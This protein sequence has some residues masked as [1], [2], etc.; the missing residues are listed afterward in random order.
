MYYLISDLHAEFWFRNWHSRDYSRDAVNHISKWF[1]HTP[2]YIFVAG[3]IHPDPNIRE[4]F[5]NVVALAAR[6]HRDR[7][8]T[9]L[10]NH[11][12]YYRT[13]PYDDTGKV[14][15]I[16]GVK[17]LIGTMWTDQWNGDPIA[18]LNAA[19]HMTDGRVIAGWSPESMS[20]VFNRFVDMIKTEKPDA[21]MTHHAPFT[22][23]IH[24]KY[25]SYG[26]MNSLFCNDLSMPV[27]GLGEFLPKV[28]LHGHCHDPFDY[29]VEGSKRSCHVIAN[30]LGYPNELFKSA[31]IGEYRAK[32]FA[33]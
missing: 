4:E 19:K 9:V 22:K 29:M 31:H 11:D 2:S 16:D 7:V 14:I 18:T 1:E 32:S 17:W 10:G 13:F 12:W 8:I 3:D 26:S 24:R 27:Y 15:E 23:S 5:L 6:I 33:V 28:W 20:V 25:E 30:P 21:I